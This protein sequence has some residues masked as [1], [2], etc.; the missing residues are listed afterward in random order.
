VRTIILTQE[1][2]ASL[3][4]CYPLYAKAEDIRRLD[5]DETKSKLIR[6][7]HPRYLTVDSK[8]TSSRWVEVEFL[9]D[10]DGYVECSRP[11]GGNPH[12]FYSGNINETLTGLMKF[13]PTIAYGNPIRVAGRLVFS[14][15]TSSDR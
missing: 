14:F 2:A 10:K 7:N 12:L 6:F 11:T 1:I 8:A 13:R 5:S 4:G 9:I 15:D 3:S